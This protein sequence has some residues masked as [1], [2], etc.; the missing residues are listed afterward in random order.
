MKNFLLQAYPFHSGKR[1]LEIVALVLLVGFVFEYTFLP[2]NVNK[3]EHLFTYEV[4]CLIHSANGALTYGLF[5]LLLGKLVRDEH[6]KLYKELLAIFVVLTIIGIN[7]FFLRRIIYDN[8]N[9]E[10]WAYL[11]E[12][13]GHAYLVGPLLFIGITMGNFFML[14]ASHIRQAGILPV[15]RNE[16]TE[17]QGESVKLEALVKNDHFELAPDDLLYAKAEGNYVVFV[18]RSLAGS[19]QLMKRMTLQ[20]TLDQLEKYPHIIKTHRAYAVNVRHV[21]K[22]AGNAQGYQLTVAHVPEQ[23]PVSRNHLKA[24][25]QQMG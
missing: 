5:F 12:E 4:I 15:S 10:S 7:N 13:I 2:F 9:N 16:T 18:I 25:N 19:E 11:W 14:N 3:S 22:V 21:L 23:V 1:L 17:E 20:S 8:V 6:W 24:F